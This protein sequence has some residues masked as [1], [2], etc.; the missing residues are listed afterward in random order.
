MT[1]SLDSTKQILRNL[2]SYSVHPNQSN[3]ELVDYIVRYLESHGIESE[4][5]FSPDMT[6]A[7]LFATIGEKT[8]G[9]IMLCGHT[10]VVSV[11]GQNW[12]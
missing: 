9:G 11:E 6:R 2:V 1:N 8:G 3:L 10:D 5:V 4:L 7:N 12:E